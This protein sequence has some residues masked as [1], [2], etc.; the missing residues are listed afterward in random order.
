MFW[1]G[2]AGYLHRSIISCQDLQKVSGTF[3]K[4]NRKLFHESACN[5]LE[6]LT[7]HLEKRVTQY[8]RYLKRAR[9]EGKK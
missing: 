4:Q 7:E 9:P 8:F 3:V 2:V 6:V 1:G 5:F